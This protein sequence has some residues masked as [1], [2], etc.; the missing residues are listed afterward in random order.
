VAEGVSLP[1]GLKTRKMCCAMNEQ[2]INRIRQCSTLPS[3][4]AI[5]IQVLELAQKADVDIAEIARTISKD[6]ALSTKILRT[7]NSSFYAR[8][9]HVSTISHALVILGLQSVK[10]LVLGFSLVTNLI[11]GKE[12]GFKHVD[13]WRRSIYSATAARTIGV[14]A[15]LVQQEEAF[16]A[17]LL[18]DLGMLVLD[19]VLGDEY[20]EIHKLAPTHS[21]LSAV[22]IKSLGCDHAEVGGFLASNW[23]LPPVL[24][25]PIT[26][27]HNPQGMTDPALRKLVDVVSLASRCA[28]IFVDPVPGPAIADVRRL[29]QSQLKLDE[30][31][32]DAM[33]H[34]IGER[35]KET[36]SLFEIKIGSSISFEAILKKAN[37]TLVELTLQTQQQ[38]TTLRAEATTLAEQNHEL[39]KQATTDGLTGL[40]NRAQFDQF[41]ATK[42]DES[43]RTVK[44]LSLLLMDVDK[45]KSVND[46]HGHQTGDKVLQALGK[47]LGTSARAQDLAARYGGE[48]MCLILPGTGRATA[49]AIAESIRRSIAAKPVVCGAISLPITAS[50]GVAT[51]EPNGP[52]R[53]P[54]HLLKAAD[55][56]VYNAKHSG[57]NCVRV[58]TLNPPKAAV[59]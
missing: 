37:E 30:T 5:A 16:L 11:G 58:F 55:L 7:V 21:D 2:L 27:H 45:F 10:T 56:A 39:K 9:Q 15:G 47:L 25:T 4:P 23:K 40:A 51:Y 50:I 29:C 8:S 35:T 59:A 18:K 33:L 36:A 24:T 48:E 13:Y 1:D 26:F 34:E 41:L 3:L 49:T 19:Q 22:E 44:P 43:I 57:R 14:K 28:D 32:C 20:G 17:A 53:T 6:P 54:A 46:R 42:F 52:L 38:A 31:Q 12:K